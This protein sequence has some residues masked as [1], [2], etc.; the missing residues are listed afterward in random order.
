MPDPLQSLSE[1]AERCRQMQRSCNP[2]KLPTLASDVA[3]L[4]ELL[5]HTIRRLDSQDSYAQ[6][7]ID[8]GGA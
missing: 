7:Q 3:D 8:R 4:A 2:S 5:Q 1:I 6:E